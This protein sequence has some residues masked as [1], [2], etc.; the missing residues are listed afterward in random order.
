MKRGVEHRNLRQIRPDLLRD[1]D[2]GKVGGVVQRRER[3]QRLDRLNRCL[4][5]ERRRA[6]TLP[7]MHHPVTDR[8]EPVD[9]G[10]GKSVRQC[11]QRRRDVGEGRRS[12]VGP[13]VRLDLCCAASAFERIVAG[14]ENLAQLLGVLENTD[15]QARTAAIDH[16]YC[17]LYTSRCV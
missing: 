2:G 7:T 15:L 5:E 6:E 1:A 10:V 17:L 3:C 8:I 9:P 4:V 16:Q 11:S 13:S 14:L 12:G